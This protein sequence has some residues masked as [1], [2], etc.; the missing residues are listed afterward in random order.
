MA[1]LTGNKIKDTY[2][3]LLKTADNGQVTSVSKNITDGLGSGSGLYL[4]D[5]GVVLS[6]SVALSGITSASQTNVLTYDTASG[7]IYYTASSAIGGGGVAVSNFTSSILEYYVDK[8][9]TGSCNVT[10]NSTKT[11]TSTNPN[12][13]TQI[14]ASKT[15]DP[16]KPYPDPWSAAFAASASIATG[17]TTSAR[18]IIKTGNEYTYGSSTLAQNGDTTGSLTNNIAPDVAVS[19]IDYSAGV[20]DLMYPNVEYYFEPESALYNINKSWTQELVFYTSSNWNIAPEFKLTGQ[21]KFVLVYGQAQ[22]F[23]AR[24]GTIVAPRTEIKIEGNHF[25]QNMGGGW[26]LTGQKVDVEANKWWMYPTGNFLLN[27][28][29]STFNYDDTF[30]NWPSQSLVYPSYSIGLPIV[31]VNID[32]Y[33]CGFDL[34]GGLAPYTNNSSVNFDMGHPYGTTYNI[35]LK[36]TVLRSRHGDGFFRI[37]PD[38]NITNINN[39]TFRNNNINISMLNVSAS[40]DATNGTHLFVPFL[41]N[42]LYYEDCTWNINVGKFNAFGVGLGA[43]RPIQNMSNCTIRLHCEDYRNYGIISAQPSSSPALPCLAY[44]ITYPNSSS[45]SPVSSGS[46]TNNQVIISGNYRNYVAGGSL[47][48]YSSANILGT[49][50]TLGTTLIL[51]NFKGYQLTESPNGISAVTIKHRGV[52][53]PSFLY[54][55]G[56]LT[57]IKDSLIYATGSTPVIGWYN[58]TLSDKRPTVILDNVAINKDISGNINYEGSVDVSSNIGRIIY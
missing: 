20:F 43:G 9:F 46:Y 53:N 50:N 34:F 40:R 23:N 52:F 56:S 11:I 14:S 10:I 41:G 37:A 31:N 28:I 45:L 27:A 5:T 32:E 7:Q 22:G 1:S 12:Y 57:L 19:Q 6:G 49:D 24:Y 18:V 3:S 2:Q 47:V 39:S 21:G 33:R 25:I 30:W 51:D 44:I 55:T 29:T 15:G 8:R 48:M 38:A 13:L 36:N 42:V 16:N 4:K 26:R 35:N 58:D 17:L 54:S